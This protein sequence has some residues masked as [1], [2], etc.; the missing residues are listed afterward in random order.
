MRPVERFQCEQFGSDTAA[1][2]AAAATLKLT[3][4]TFLAACILAENNVKL[5]L[6]VMVLAL[7]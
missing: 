7:D 3:H 2:L 1:L 6:A 5:E 4:G